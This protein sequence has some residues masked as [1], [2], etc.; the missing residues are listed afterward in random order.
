VPV[1]SGQTG[2]PRDRHGDQS[3]VGIVPAAGRG[4]R[5][6]ADGPKAF[7]VC[8]GR[9]LIDWSL[10]VLREV[11]DRV[12]VAVPPGFSYPGS[13]EG[14]PVRSDS[15]RR[16]LAAAPEATVA[17]VHDAA[18]PLLTRE[19]VERCIA[20]LGDGVDGAVA[21]SPV[22]DTVKQVDSELRV[23][24]TLDRSALWAIQTPQVFNAAVLRR[25]L[26]VPLEA[27]KA[28]TDDAALVE[29][30]GGRVRVVEA[31]SSNF[32]VTGPDDL[33]RAAIALRAS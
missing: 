3:V 26:D 11:C 17:V 9:P 13:V 30:A 22:V 18:R 29:A 8:A 20:A 7:V 28:A 25:A 10:D 32:K 4:E 21:A 6:G 19:L 1:V 33:E 24:R 31:R 27:L 12:V 15:V 5:L 2:R 23:T 16:A 14:G